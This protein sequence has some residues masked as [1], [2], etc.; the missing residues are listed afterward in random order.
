M[1][2]RDR[3]ALR[4]AGKSMPRALQ[5]TMKH[6]QDAIWSSPTVRLSRQ[7]QPVSEPQRCRAAG[8]PT[9]RFYRKQPSNTR[10]G[11]DVSD[12]SKAPYCYAC[13]AKA[14]RPGQVTFQGYEILTD[15]DYEKLHVMNTMALVL[16]GK[17]H[18]KFER[19][20][21]GHADIT[22]VF[23]AD[24]PKLSNNFKYELQDWKTQGLHSFDLLKKAMERKP[25][26]AYEILQLVN[27]S[28]YIEGPLEHHLQVRCPL[29]D[30]R[31]FDYYVNE[32]IQIMMELHETPR[33]PRTCEGRLRRKYYQDIRVACK[34][35]DMEGASD[36]TP[37]ESLKRYEDDYQVEFEID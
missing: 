14:G 31:F 4:V 35:L 5:F 36:L 37:F 1:N 30:H 7:M 33:C 2:V 32:T 18:I 12:T 11:H 17:L 13:L 3:G 16:V 20:T 23:W 25:H 34:Y 28:Y 9:L 21:Q 24:N 10:C 27:E 8:S 29:A 22:N 6:G 15:K 19:L 26:K